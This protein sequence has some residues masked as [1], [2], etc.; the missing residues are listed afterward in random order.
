MDIIQRDGTL[1]SHYAPPPGA[2]LLD[3]E[4]GIAAGGS[5]GL[6]GISQLR[7]LLVQG[8]PSYRLTRTA[9]SSVYR[10]FSKDAFVA[11]IR[12]WHTDGRTFRPRVAAS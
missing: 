3:D 8:E 12:P 10:W 4:L 5:V 6:G 1:V 9:S 7:A 11:P 2:Y